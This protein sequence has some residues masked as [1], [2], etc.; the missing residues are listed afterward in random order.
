MVDDDNKYDELVQK[1]LEKVVLS[2]IPG[3]KVNVFIVSMVMLLS[4]G[5]YYY[6][7]LLET[8]LGDVAIIQSFLLSS[9]MLG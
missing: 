7:G 5:T 3:I 2:Y 8:Q 4:V 9:Y 6:T 1:K